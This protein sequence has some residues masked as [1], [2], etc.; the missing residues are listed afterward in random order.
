M[1]N[2]N[3]K[4]LCVKKN[5]VFFFC[6]NHA[7]LRQVFDLYSRKDRK[8]VLVEGGNNAEKAFSEL[9]EALLM[10]WYNRLVLLHTAYCPFTTG[11]PHVLLDTILTWLIFQPV[12]LHSAPQNLLYMQPKCTRTLCQRLC[13]HLNVS[14]M[15]KSVFKT[16]QNRRHQN[17][18]HCFLLRLIE[19]KSRL[20]QQ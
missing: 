5:F 20:I 4:K 16:R 12:V 15:S 13:F 3:I 10:Q 9:K 7:W 18:I 2:E 14:L 11:L 19:V 17:L 6:I 8:P 1:R